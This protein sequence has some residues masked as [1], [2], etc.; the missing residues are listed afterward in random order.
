MEES[1][2]KKKIETI[3]TGAD[4]QSIGLVLCLIL[5]TSL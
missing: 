5:K 4:N 1:K 3:N 2:F